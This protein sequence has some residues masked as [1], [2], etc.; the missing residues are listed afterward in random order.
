MEL[1]AQQFKRLVRDA[2]VVDAL[3]GHFL[4]AIT[5]LAPHRFGLHGSLDILGQ[6]L[7]QPRL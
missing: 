4:F 6:L 7:D 3:A 5:G 1:F 2:A